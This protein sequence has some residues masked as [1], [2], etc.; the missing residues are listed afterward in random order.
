MSGQVIVLAKAPVAGLVKTRLCPPCTPAQAALI[1]AAALADTLAVVSATG[2]TR[3]V[4]AVAGAYPCP[5][6]WVSIP[7]RGNTLG[8]RLASAFADTAALAATTPS[9]SASFTTASAPTSSSSSRKSDLSDSSTRR[10]GAQPVVLVGMDTPQLTAAHLRSALD[11]LIA[12]DGPDATLGLA[13]DGG[14]WTLGLRDPRHAEILAGIATSTPSTGADTRAALERR[15]L[16]V[17]LLA[18]LRDVDTAADAHHVAALCPPGSRFAEAVA[19]H[20]PAAAPHTSVHHMPGAAPHT[21]ASVPPIAGA[22]S[23]TQAS[24]RHVPGAVD[25]V[26]ALDQ[27]GPGPDRLV[28]DP[29]SPAHTSVAA[30]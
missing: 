9:A 21:P 1:A 5:P 27:P 18:N 25:R 24:D 13:E 8:E 15:G 28:A 26:R 17:H 11:P 14:W 6:G 23:H 16:A 20:I 22:A 2:V 4:L 29:G 30:R 19:H 3:R 12:T 7:Q 10:G